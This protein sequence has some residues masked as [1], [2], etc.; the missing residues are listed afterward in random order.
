MISLALVLKHF[1][2]KNKATTLLY[3]TD[4]QPRM[5]TKT[6]QL[7]RRMEKFSYTQDVE[8]Y[9]KK[10]MKFKI[11]CSSFSSVNG[12]EF[13]HVIIMVNQSEYYLKYYLPQAISRCTYD[14]TFVLMPEEKLVIEKVFLHDK[15]KETVANIVEELKLECLVKQVVVADCNDCKKNCYC[16][17]KG[18][19][20]RQKFGV[21]AHS[22]Q[23]KD[24]SL[25]L[26]NYAELEEG[27]HDTS[28]RADAK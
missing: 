28:A 25:Q 2:G 12:M 11:F 5:L 3:M 16:L 13:D 7:L 9:F 24:Y 15:T 27:P 10:N 21:H 4:E 18:A 6:I 8:E 1:I 19:Q 23:Y 17:P 14:L 22:Q 26:A 20:D